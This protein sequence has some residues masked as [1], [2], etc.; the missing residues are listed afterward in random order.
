VIA[1]CGWP[2]GTSTETQ[3]YQVT[4]CRY[5]P[6]EIEIPAF[7][8]QAI[9]EAPRIIGFQIFAKAFRMK[10]RTEKARGRGFRTEGVFALHLQSVRRDGLRPTAAP[11]EGAVPGVTQK[12]FCSGL[13]LKDRQVRVIRKDKEQVNPT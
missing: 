13:Y 11:S 5:T 8:E 12:I 1:W 10:R 4:I 3:S 9:H 2:E 7:H 6:G